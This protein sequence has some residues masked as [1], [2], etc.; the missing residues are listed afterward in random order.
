M[1]V[2]PFELLGPTVAAAALA[3]RLTYSRPRAVRILAASAGAIAANL[4][5]GSISFA[6]FFLGIV[7]PVSAATLVLMAGYLYAAFVK[8]D[9]VASRSLLVCLLIIGV[10]FYPLTFGLSSLDPYELGYRGLAIPMLMLIV[11]VIGWAAHAIDI[12]CWIAVTA[13]LY[14]IHA[15]DSANLWDYLIFPVDPIFAAAGLTIDLR[16]RRNKQDREPDRLRQ[17]A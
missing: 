7:G 9:Y 2:N 14:V 3:V 13:L 12:H 15:Y 1:P 11:V 16:R 5:V 17:Q 8:P 10:I 6:T 4:P